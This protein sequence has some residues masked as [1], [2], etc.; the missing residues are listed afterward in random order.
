MTTPWTPDWANGDSTPFGCQIAPLAFPIMIQRAREGRPITYEDL[1]AEIERR[2]KIPQQ[3]RKGRYGSAVGLV[4]HKIEELGEVWGELLPPLNT[5]VINKWKKCA[6][7]G[8][9]PLLTNY[10]NAKG[11]RFYKKQRKE[12]H[13]VARDIV[14]DYGERW[15]AVAEAFGARVLKP[16]FGRT[17]PGKP[18][19]LPKVG[20]GGGE[21]TPEH[22]NLKEWVAR[23]PGFVQRFGRF[24]VG[25]TEFPL[26]S[27]DRLDVHFGEKAKRLAVE[28]KPS[29][30]PKEEFERGVFQ[31]VK[32][33]AV[34][35]AEQIA[36]C[37]IPQAEAVLVTTNSP[38]PESRELMR[39][40]GVVHLIAPSH[41]EK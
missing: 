3:F 14:F 10:L 16:A 26:S 15:V 25:V 27:G 30:A 18:L 29:H 17:G 12:L 38:H 20:Q 5:I 13:R 36:Q 34:L 28:V 32:Y 22:R 6:G 8:G 21:E 24:D 35:R 23:N 7:T 40:L 11:Q 2:H 41:A 39:R 9:D 37:L 4:G 19:K 31:V 33:R 1:A